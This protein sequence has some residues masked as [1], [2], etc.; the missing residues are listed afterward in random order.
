MTNETHLLSLSDAV[1]QSVFEDAQ[2]TFTSPCLVGPPAVEYAPYGRTPDSRRRRIDTRAG[3]IDQDPEFMAFLEGLANPITSKE[4]SADALVDGPSVK[5]EKVTTTP[6]VQYLKDKK[7]NKS[8]E[9]AAKAAKKQE[10]QLA[11]GKS[12]K[13]GSSEAAKKKARDAKSD[14]SV[15]K[16]AKDAVKILNREASSKSAGGASSEPAVSEN[17]PPAK[18]DIGKVPARQRG[19]AIAKHIDRLQ[20]DL[21]FSPAQAHRQ[22]RRDVADAQRAERVAAAA[23]KAVTESKDATST[24]AQAQT[25]PTAPKVSV[26][27]PRNRRPQ[28][29]GTITELDASKASAQ[30]SPATGSSTPMVLL[31]KPE[32]A[33]T[34]SPATAAPSAKPAPTANARKQPPVAVPSEGATQAFVKH[35]NPSQGVTEPLLKEAMEKFGAVSMV[36]IDKRK[37]FAY[38]DFVDTEGLK[39]A[40]AA[41]PISVAQGTVQVMQRKGTALP[42]EKKPAHQTP[43][44]PHAPSRGGRGGRG[45]TIGR[46]GGRGGARGGAAQAGSSEAA[47]APA[48]APTGPAK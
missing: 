16:A 15:E 1:R 19:A 20:R 23:D 11:K 26:L 17:T 13:E 6:L 40:M 29:K 31:K 25:I 34:T 24:Q 48:S 21:G 37:G 8:K 35:A 9:A 47:K 43:H 3:T 44:A 4:I 10:A 32:A 42:P 14:K 12:S 33:Q 7:A 36:E 41:N 38:V 30:Q 28:G 2:N 22:V 39:K 45:G 46:R 27:Q 5:Q 18:L